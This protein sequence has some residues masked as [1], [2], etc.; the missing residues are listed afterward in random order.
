MDSRTA[1]CFFWVVVLVPILL[2]SSPSNAR[3]ANSSLSGIVTGPS[4]AA[5]AQAK[6]SVK[7]LATG[8]SAETQTNLVGYYNISSLAP[9]DY[10]VSVSAGGFDTKEANVT[11]TA[12][13]QQ[14][15]DFR[16]VAASNPAQEL[17]LGDLGISPSEVKGNPQ[18]QALLDKRSHMLQVHQKL[19]L[20]TLAPMTAAVFSSL[21]AKRRR[22]TPG[23][24]TG[25]DVHTALGGLTAGMY[26]TSA[27]F[28]IRAPKVPGTPTHGHI[29]LHKGLAWI[30]GPGMILTPILGAMAYSQLSNGER[31]HGIAKAHSEVALTTFGAYV[32]AMLSVTLK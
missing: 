26:F 28:A 31:V 7:N 8:Q 13:A 24:P 5:V 27:Y 29:R 9:G 11:L 30:H 17:S 32:A 25:R 12:G 20:I 10:E 4:Q 22:G 6:V 14:T 3:A 1:Q 21:A 2:I 19:G 15:L 16:L 18:E 23:N